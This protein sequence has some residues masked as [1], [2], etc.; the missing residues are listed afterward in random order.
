MALEG[1]VMGS[2]I[3]V[4][5]TGF[6]LV[7][8]ACGNYVNLAWNKLTPPS[9]EG[10]VVVYVIAYGPTSGSQAYKYTVG[11]DETS[12]TIAGVGGGA[13]GKHYFELWA[14]PAPTNGPH[15]G[16]IEVTVTKP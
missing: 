8:V 14:D 1:E 15:A 16:P 3:T 4:A 13:A 9:G 10:P 2:P 5:P 12:V 7:S 6:R 11:P